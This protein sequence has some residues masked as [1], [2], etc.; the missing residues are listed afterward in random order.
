MPLDLEIIR[1]S[2][3][4]RLGPRDELDFEK[5]KE[6]LRVMAQ[7]CRTRN[8]DRAVLDLRRLPV[9]VKKLFTREQLSALVET[10]H[11]AG[12]TRR[13]RLAVLYRDDPHHGIRMFA[14]IG[15]LQGWNVRAFSD[16]EKAFI[17]VSADEAVESNV[18]E[19]AV[20]VRVISK[21]VRIHVGAA[22]GKSFS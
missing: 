13:Q 21:K 15:M 22:G 11:E 14:F 17:W 10:F 4:V 7:A 20:P 2:E 8:I 3:F 16:F 19:C 5:S 6:A 1:A 12:F 18:G 9:P